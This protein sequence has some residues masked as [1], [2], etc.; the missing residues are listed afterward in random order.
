MKKKL[1]F[2]ALSSAIL[3]GC[4]TVDPGSGTTS[5]NAQMASAEA[6]HRQ[7]DWGGL[8]AYIGRQYGN[9]DGD[10]LRL[11]ILPD[12]SELRIG[13][14]SAN[15]LRDTARIGLV[16]RPTAVPDTFHFRIENS[17][18]FSDDQA[19]VRFDEQGRMQVLSGSLN[20]LQL[21]I[22][23]DKAHFSYRASASAYRMTPKPLRRSIYALNDGSFLPVDL[24]PQTA[25]QQLRAA[26]PF[27]TWEQL[28]GQTFV[29]NTILLRVEKDDA[30][31]LAFVYMD[32]NEEN[33]GREIFAPS[34][35]TDPKAFRAV[36]LPNMPAGTFSTRTLSLQPDDRIIHGYDGTTRDSSR[37][38][39][40]THYINEGN[41]IR[42][43]TR[44]QNLDN[45]SDS[46][47]NSLYLPV[48]RERLAT[49]MENRARR[50]IEQ[51]RDR[52]YAEREAAERS[53]RNRQTGDAILRGLASGFNQASQSNMRMAQQ[54]LDFERKLNQQLR[55]IE[56][57]KQQRDQEA[58]KRA[59]RI[60][61]ANAKARS[62][63][64]SA[65]VVSQQMQAMG[66]LPS[67]NAQ[68]ELR[69]QQDRL[70]QEQ[71]QAE[72]LRAAEQAR[73]SL[74]QQRQEERRKKDEIIRQDKE[75]QA[76]ALQEHLS[77]EKR[78]IRLQAKKCPAKGGLPSVIGIRPKVLPKVANCITVHFEARCPA[79]RPGT[80]MTGS[81]WAY[82]GWGN[83]TESGDLPRQLACDEREAIVEVTSVKTCE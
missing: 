66:P 55:E 10:L 35:P 71:R 34:S 4:V 83:C 76:Q 18:L 64:D 6:S 1:F 22:D 48:T 67:S 50:K 57:Q 9:E 23:H 42:I 17:G 33:P 3:A 61:A 7:I 14:F 49:A 65:A 39:Q 31:N 63:S 47:W 27:G 30:G 25:Y 51:E 37:I 36:S 15:N 41:A 78:S 60:M 19:T 73:G 80:G 29:G 24:A 21:T 32:L 79:E 40:V 68:T 43:I 45:D 74:E 46:T 26:R 20:D 5:A 12:Q 59:D 13:L 38:A 53:E 72:E 75:R 44:Y 82:N 8:Q 58:G 70:Q 11:T 52:E 69:G 2:I 77:A 54:S 16:V 56:Q 62:S 81:I 28:L